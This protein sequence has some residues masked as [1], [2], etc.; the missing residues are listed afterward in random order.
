[1]PK[2][3]MTKAMNRSETDTQ[4]R[5]Y[6]WYKCCATGD[7]K[8]YYSKKIY[9]KSV[10]LHFKKCERCKN[11]QWN[12]CIDTLNVTGMIEPKSIKVQLTEYPTIESSPL[13]V[14]PRRN[15]ESGV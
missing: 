15:I 10:E 11:A 9:D 4:G 3:Q 2:G 12:S 5:S 14:F 7:R 13:F 1:M 6:W 8:L